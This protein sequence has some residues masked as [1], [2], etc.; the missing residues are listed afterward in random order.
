MNEYLK[1]ED[2]EEV[3]LLEKIAPEETKSEASLPDDQ[4]KA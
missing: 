3:S 1:E 4:V 2:I